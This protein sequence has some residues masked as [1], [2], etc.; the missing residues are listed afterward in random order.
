MKKLL[1]LILILTMAF[2]V[3]APATADESSPAEA[4]PAPSQE[5]SA[6]KED[7]PAPSPNT[8]AETAPDASPSTDNKNDHDSRPKLSLVAEGDN[9]SLI[10]YGNGKSIPEQGMNKASKHGLKVRVELSG[11]KP[12]ERIKGKVSI[13]TDIDQPDH[14]LISTTVDKAKL[15]GATAY[16]FT[17][18]QMKKLKAGKTY[19]VFFKTGKSDKYQP[20]ARTLIGEIT[21][22]GGTPEAT[23]AEGGEALDETGKTGLSDSLAAAMDASSLLGA[24][25]NGTV[26]VQPKDLRGVLA[27]DETSAVDPLTVELGVTTSL[28][29]TMVTTGTATTDVVEG[30]V[31][32]KG[33]GAASAYQTSVT[34]PST[35]VVG[36]T[37]FTFSAAQLNTLAAGSY[38]VRFS[39]KATVDYK[40]HL[41][42]QVG[43]L[44]VTVTDGR[45]ETLEIKTASLSSDTWNTNATTGIDVEFENGSSPVSVDC[46]INGAQQTIGYK[47]VNLSN[48]G[49][50]A[51][52]SADELRT[53]SVGGHDVYYVFR[54]D[55]TY[56]GTAPVKIDTLT[57]AE[58]RV[59]GAI[60]MPDPLTEITYT[61]GGTN[62]ADLMTFP[63]SLTEPD[64]V[65]TKDLEGDLSVNVYIKDGGV[66]AAKRTL[67]YPGTTEATFTTNDIASL[68]AGTHDVCASSDGNAAYKSIGEVKIGTL[69]IAAG[70]ADTALTAGTGLA[71]KW[72]N[73]K[74]GSLPVTVPLTALKAGTIAADTCTL[75]VQGKDVGVKNAAVT[76]SAGNLTQNMSFTFAPDDL[77]VLP[78]GIYTLVLD[79][80]LTDDYAPLQAEVGTLYISDK[81][82]LRYDGTG[83]IPLNFEWTRGGV[84]DLNGKAINVKFAGGAQEDG[85]AVHVNIGGTLSADG[86]TLTGGQAVTNT[87]VNIG[88]GGTGVVL[89]IVLSDLSGLPDKLNALPTDA[90]TIWVYT[91]ESSKNIAVPP[92]SLGTVTVVSNFAATASTLI[93][94]WA[95]GTMT[96]GL[97]VELKFTGGSANEVEATIT[98]TSTL[99]TNA[100]VPT[101]FTG[102]VKASGTAQE[103]TLQMS[104]AALNAMATGTYNLTLTTKASEY[105]KAISTP[106]KLG[107]LTVT[108]KF[109][110]DTTSKKDYAI[111]WVKGATTLPDPLKVRFS[112]GSGIEDEDKVDVKITASTMTQ[113]FTVKSSNPDANGK[114]QDI[115]LG[116]WSADKLNNLKIG[117]YD[118]KLSVAATAHN[119][120]IAETKI[121]ELTVTSALAYSGK[122][123]MAITWFKGTT[124]KNQEITVS[125][126]GGYGDDKVPGTFTVGTLAFKPTLNTKM[127]TTFSLSSASLNQLANGEHKMTIQTTATDDNRA[128]AVTNVGTLTVVQKPQITT[129]TLAGG[130]LSTDYSAAVSFVGYPTPE[131][132]ITKGK[133]PKGLKMDAAGKI[134][135]KPTKSGK[136]TFTVTAT[137]KIEGVEYTASKQLS[138]AI[139]AGT[140]SSSGSTTYGTASNPGTTNTGDESKNTGSGAV[141]DGL[142]SFGTFDKLGLNTLNWILSKQPAM[143]REFLAYLLKQQSS[144]LVAY[145]L[146]WDAKLTTPLSIPIVGGGK[147]LLGR[148]VFEPGTQGG[149][150][151]FNWSV[152][153]EAG[154]DM[155]LLTLRMG[156]DFEELMDTS[157]LTQDDYYEPG[158]F[159][160]I[161]GLTMVQL[162]GQVAFDV[163]Q[164]SECTVDD[165]VKNTIDNWLNG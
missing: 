38:E 96:A 79:I 20:I 6:P 154:V 126:K 31:T 68:G 18:K 108:S 82:L 84:N 24:L 130:K 80:S 47:T 136:A 62:A 150:T 138:I 137:N 153:A 51:T 70:D 157:D 89:P 27:V 81:T 149:F 121:G 83:A 69:A 4:T 132:T 60:V 40:A 1:S 72:T 122:T 76:F 151:G 21:I 63:V 9:L 33:T 56:A 107:T 14:D 111:T 110:L 75:S 2:A 91:K 131:L 29:V 106:V 119:A 97:P 118:L 123:D 74:D 12:K 52:F 23:P 147:Y 50:K 22:A 100:P 139:A 101:V 127:D 11:G 143:G 116:A 120:A 88:V 64:A 145:P 113:T 109:A 148:A 34:T 105:D 146:V 117:K 15:S 35:K 103:R 55:D 37:D 32:L 26:E 59:Q 16:K 92:V 99:T 134:T 65:G 13:G 141:P 25:E 155:S 128:V 10:T 140:S 8:D 71:Y 42:A 164:L 17:P 73:G 5:T 19:K 57:I 160:P 85:V 112:G 93:L 67:A 114:E 58:N 43:S 30:T 86:L 54:G 98:A 115:P 90:N 36:S 104:A 44:T 135:G 133:L 95:K 156:A 39:S 46:Y 94:E 48:N 129:E 61:I 78:D 159:L 3:F 87:T 77:Y 45:T 125:F 162:D 49:A 102:K 161:S 158:D 41:D 124:D 142:V 152:E 7:A 53:L 165:E 163:S 66:I 144:Q 28:K